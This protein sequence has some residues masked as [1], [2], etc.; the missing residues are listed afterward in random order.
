[1]NLHAK[2]DAF[3]RSVTIISISYPTIR[4]SGEARIWQTEL[5]F[6]V[7]KVGLQF[8]LPKCLGS[9]SGKVCSQRG[10]LMHS[11]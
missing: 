10:F 8:E 11:L 6:L 5:V 4:T 7:D 1:M 9:I 2:F 3:I